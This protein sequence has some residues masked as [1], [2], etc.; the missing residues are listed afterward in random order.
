MDVPIVLPL[1]LEDGENKPECQNAADQRN[2][3]FQ[4]LLGQGET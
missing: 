1:P 4:A 3:D 2:L